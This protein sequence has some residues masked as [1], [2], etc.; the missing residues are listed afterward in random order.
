MHESVFVSDFFFEDFGVSI[1][2]R[3]ETRLFE[4]SLCLELAKSISKAAL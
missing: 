2:T 1:L 3:Y 4:V